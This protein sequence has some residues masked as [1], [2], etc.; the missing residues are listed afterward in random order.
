MFLKNKLSIT[1]ASA[2]LSTG[3]L[4]P[5]VIAEEVKDSKVTAEKNEKEKAWDVLNPPGEK[6]TVNI[7]TK[8]LTWTNLDV[9]PDGDTIVFDMLGDIYIVDIDG[10]EAKALTSD[11]AW[12]F[13]PKFSPDGKSIAFVS[14]RGG[15]DNI[16]TMDS[17]G[18]NLHQVSKAKN[19]LLHNPAW[20]PDGQFIVAKKG[21]ITSRSIPAGSIWMFHRSGGDGVEIRERLHGEK[22]QKNVA[23]PSFAKDGKKVYYS[24]DAT[25]G[26][27][28]QY[29]KNS[30]G[31]IFEI[32]TKNL[33][34]GEEDIV[35]SGAGGAIRPIESPDGKYLA[36]IRRVEMQSALF[37]KDLKSGKETQIY[38]GIDRDL[39]EAGGSQGNAPAYAWTPDSDE[40]VFWAKGKIH[41][42]E[43]DDKEAK[44][45]PVHVKTTKQVTPALKFAVDVAPDTFK[46]KM[47]RWMQV[48]PDGE[49][50]VFQALGRLYIRDLDSG[51]VKRLTRSDDEFEYYPSLSKDG[52]SVVYT[53]WSD[54]K[55]GSVKVVSLKNRRSKTITSEPGHYIAPAFSNDGKYVVYEK[56]TGG[57]LLSPEWS[58]QPGIYVA[59]IDGDN[60]KR[61]VKDGINPQFSSDSQRI[62]F[63]KEVDETKMSLHSVNLSGK[64]ERDHYEGEYVT[65]FNI[66]P[67]N[68]WL[69][70]VQHHKVFLTPFV[71]RGKVIK[72]DQD[73]KSLGLPAKQ[74]SGRSGDFLAWRGDSQELTWGFGSKLYRRTLK[75]TFEFLNGEAKALPEPELEGIEITFK[76]K[77]DKP[78]GM[79][80]LVGGRVVTM[81]DAD[82]TQEVIEDGVVIVENNRII[83]VGKKGEVKIPSKAKQV[84][85]SGKTV[86][87]GLVD[88]HAHGSYASYGI[89]P[90]QNW[91]QYS[92]LSF[93]V[94][95]IHDPSNDT[96]EVFSMSEMV[97]AGE[98]VGPRIYSTGRILYAGHANGY[99][100]RINSYD[101]AKFHVQRL[102]DAGAISVKSY[103]HTSRKVRQ[104]VIAAG[105]E[106]GIMVVPEGGAKF[107]HNINQVVDGHTGVEHA[108]PVP[109]L[110]GD[111]QQLWSQTDA[112]Y[113][114]TFVV[115]YGGL[116]GENYW[117]HHTNV[118]EN[119]RLMSYVPKYI[120][121]PRSMR[122]AKAPEHHY[123]HI[124]VAKSAK[125]LRDK[126]V[127]VQIG[128]HGQREGLAAHWELWMMVQGGF[129]PWEAL[130]SGT[131]DGAR[132]LAMDKDIGSIEKG[133]LADLM[134]VDGNPLKDIRQSEKVAY[135]M[136]NGRLYDAAS[137]NEVGN[138][139]NERQEFFFESGQQTQMH[140]ATQKMM[141]EKAHRY[142]WKH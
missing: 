49:S 34:T 92:N 115:A 42:I 30:V 106:L 10:G 45:I 14:D 120:V 44:E 13:Q 9:S 98:T 86:L 110:Y 80:A 131:S 6:K 100:S 67:D 2:M 18:Q 74:V 3:M 48:T 109:N 27:R 90:Q 64:D 126:G 101:D 61:V 63:A 52:K 1:L 136:I 69:A 62:F 20:S 12:N 96:S 41:R 28:W 26:V 70:Y 23:E 122:P 36:Y 59:D 103:N 138:Y 25:P 128:A 83:A 135:T 91:N 29:D 140:P 32:R 55:L 117:Y 78:E 5:E 47:A 68:Q 60:V 141:E 114:P 124:L 50:V 129:T 79:V 118:W 108:L 73:S 37:I 134:I 104:Q 99:K 139:D 31:N 7:D 56:V 82:N 11:I 16:W 19:N 53:S 58:M 40:L 39:Q 76:Q 81:R 95:T 22:S 127:T 38:L 113:T 89:Q 54:K 77:S 84:D 94:T 21:Q 43:I 65:A 75:D 123:N 46:V 71:T 87:P 66:S 35:V 72:M 24:V 17:D 85:V 4:V 102:K 119:K 15:A 112:G 88:A 8:E 93:G 133:K 33:E 116:G 97:R 125:K 142:H 57:Y 130:R 107:Q 137:M 111:V 51:K 121:E 105:R 132:Y